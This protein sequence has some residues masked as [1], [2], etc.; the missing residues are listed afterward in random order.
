MAAPCKLSD[1]AAKADVMA[2]FRDDGFH[3]ANIGA[4]TAVG[5]DIG[6]D[7]VDVA[8]GNGINGAFIDAGA[9]CGA[10]FGNF[11]SHSGMFLVFMNVYLCKDIQL[12]IPQKW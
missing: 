6:V 8:F 9:T 1:D 5:A 2:L 11:V 12:S 10:V 7:Y 4:R 3:G